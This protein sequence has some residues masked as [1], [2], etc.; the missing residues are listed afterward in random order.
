[1]KISGLLLD[2]IKEKSEKWAVK[3][4]IGRERR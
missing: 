2:V 1:M 3:C 4:N